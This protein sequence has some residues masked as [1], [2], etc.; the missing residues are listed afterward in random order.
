MYEYQKPFGKLV[1]TSGNSAITFEF[2]KELFNFI[3]LF[4]LLLV[5]RNNGFAIAARFY[6]S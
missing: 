3:T 5:K 6:A 1:V 4:V 2:L